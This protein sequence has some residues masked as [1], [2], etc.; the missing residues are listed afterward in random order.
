V[1]AAFIP[2]PAL[3]REYGLTPTESAFLLEIVHG[4][5]LQA[6]ANRLGVSRATARTHLRHVFEKTDT[7]CQAALVLLATNGTGA[8]RDDSCDRDTAPALSL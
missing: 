5:E 1:R 8:P 3:R 7:R 2:T 6:A 4:D